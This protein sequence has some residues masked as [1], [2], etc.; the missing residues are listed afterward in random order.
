MLLD[1][2][3]S[4]INGF[5]F[6]DTKGLI[7]IGGGGSGGGSGGLED[8]SYDEAVQVFSFDNKLY[9]KRVETETQK[10]STLPLS[11]FPSFLFTFYKNRMLCFILQRS[12]LQGSA[13][14]RGCV[15]LLVKSKV[16]L[17]LIFYGIVH[18][19]ERFYFCCTFRN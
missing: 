4:K 11:S 19:R 2:L 9:K 7:I 1:K 16:I 10:P 12:L 8:T 14:I 17:I 6:S 3:S 13:V 5:F 18:T 15:C